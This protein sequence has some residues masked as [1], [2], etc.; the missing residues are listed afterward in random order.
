MEVPTPLQLLLDVTQYAPRPSQE[1]HQWKD[2]QYTLTQIQLSII[3]FPINSV[4]I[5]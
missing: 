3:K 2:I 5:G 1:G 4:Y